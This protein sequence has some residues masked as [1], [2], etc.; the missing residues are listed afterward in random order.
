M[1]MFFMNASK[2]LTLKNP[3]YEKA[4]DLYVMQ[5]YLNDV[6]KGDITTENFL[7]EAERK[8]EVIAEIMVNEPGILAGI[9]EAEWFLNKIGIKIIKSK[10]DSAPIK[11]GQ[12]IMKLQAP[13]DK[14]LAGERT[15]LNL[16]QR[17]SGVAT[18]TNKLASKLPKDINLLATRKTLWGLLDKRAVA[19]GGGGTHRLDLSDAVMIKDNHLSLAEDLTERLVNVF[20]KVKKTRFIEIEIQT[21]KE[22]ENFLAIYGELKSELSWQKIVIMLDNFKPADIKKIVPQLKKTGLDVELSGGINEQ[23]IRSYAIKGVSAISS[24]AITMKADAL[25]M[26]LHLLSK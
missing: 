11:A 22:I 18:A 1:E 16:L 2:E 23:N 20:K 6:G 10:K 17:M 25:D 13:A 14:I 19:V 4:V 7:S 9:Q 26:S 8:K 15:L 3:A 5:A 12:V 21:M 24:G